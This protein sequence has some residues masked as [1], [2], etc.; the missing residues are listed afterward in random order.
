MPADTKEVNVYLATVARLE[1]DIAMIDTGAGLASIA[2]S[3]KRIADAQTGK[4][5]QI[6]DI[7]GDEIRPATQA[8]LDHHVAFAQRV[9]RDHSGVASD[10]WKKLQAERKL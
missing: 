4:L 1:P 10:V 8:D 7:A 3:L 5:I 2:I 9:A 6:Y